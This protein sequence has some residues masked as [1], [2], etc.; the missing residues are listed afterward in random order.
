VTIKIVPILTDF[1]VPGSLTREDKEA[2]LHLWRYIG[3]LIGLNE[4]LNPC[5]TVEKASGL[6]ES[7]VIHLIHP[8]ERRYSYLLSFVCLYVSQLNRINY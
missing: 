5:V 8:D 6:L 1:S 4:D 2:Y 7:I 3:Y